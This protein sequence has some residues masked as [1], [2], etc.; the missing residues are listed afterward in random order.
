MIL[1][2]TATW[3]H[4]V[5]TAGGSVIMIDSTVRVPGAVTVEAA[6]LAAALAATAGPDLAVSPPTPDIGFVHRHFDDTEIYVVINTGPTTRTF[7]VAPKTSLA[8]YEQWDAL[9]GRVLQAGAVNEV[10]DLT[11]QAYEATVIV[12]SDGPIKKASTDSRD[13]HRLPLSGEWQ[14]AYGTEP[15]QPVD[16]PH[17][18][19]NEPGRQHYSGAATYTTTIYLG[20]IELDAVEGRAVIDFGDCEVYDGG[21]TADD[22]VGPSYQVAVRGPVGEVA[23]VRINGIECGI[24]W[25]PPYQVEITSALHSGAN[26]IEIMVY[27][28][29]ANALAADEH[30]TRLVAESEAGYGRRFR[31]QDLDQATA[32]VRSGLLQVPTLVLRI[33]SR[34]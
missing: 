34:V 4:E 16:V 24:A 15:A 3:L 28:T 31:M 25:A 5:I 23:Q 33:S 19:E 18:W 29:A 13:E 14:V 27:N 9:S 26:E 17:V 10:I 20:N 32:T 30:I 8:S 12:L 11:L 7:S 6:E 21:S 2:P 1:E 22:M